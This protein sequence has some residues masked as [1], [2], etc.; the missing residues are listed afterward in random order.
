MS[1]DNFEGFC[2]AVIEWSQKSILKIPRFKAEVD[3]KVLE[4]KKRH[5]KEMAAVYG[6]IQAEKYKN[7][8]ERAVTEFYSDYTPLLYIRT[9]DADAKEGGLYELFHQ[10]IDNDSGMVVGTTATTGP[11]PM[12]LIQNSTMPDF[13]YKTT[14]VEGWHGGAKKIA[15]EKV[16][17]WGAH[18]NPGHPMWRTRGWVTYPDG[19]RKIHRYGSW[20]VDKLPGRLKPSP[21][22]RFEKYMREAEKE[23]KDL[24]KQLHDEHVP[25]IKKER[26][27][28][29]Q[30]LFNEYFW[31]SW[32]DSLL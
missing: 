23:L 7:A 30:A 11:E 19:E 32:L 27:A 8:F 3:R 31:P 28:V 2:D 9:G 26:R 22:K 5:S 25:Q 17:T 16:A 4:I 24:K 18:P 29:K 14:F 1:D 15:P 10:D 20:K 12:D 6:P 21:Q 13:L